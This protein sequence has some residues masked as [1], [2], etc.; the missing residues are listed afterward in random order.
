MS[1]ISI[2]VGNVYTEL[3]FAIIFICIPASDG[4]IFKIQIITSYIES[5]VIIT[6]WRWQN[7]LLRGTIYLRISFPLRLRTKCTRES[8]INFSSNFLFNVTCNNNISLAMLIYLSIS[9]LIHKIKKKKCTTFV[10]NTL[11][12][13]EI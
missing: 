1:I 4:L 11:K 13:V 5:I 7:E 6:K 12:F 2:Y 9:K 3:N 10:Y 8:I